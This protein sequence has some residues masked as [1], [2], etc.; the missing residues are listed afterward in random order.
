MLRVK[1]LKTERSSRPRN[2][3]GPVVRRLRNAAELSQADLAARCGVLG[4]DLSRETM[5]K[6]ESQIRWAA[7]F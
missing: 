7:D 1:F 3:V 4:W 2:V 5:A 6:I